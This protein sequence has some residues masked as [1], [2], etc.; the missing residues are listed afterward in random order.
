MRI[1][2]ITSFNARLF[3]EYAHR[4]LA[5]FEQFWDARVD[6]HV[7]SEDLLSC[8]APSSRARM[9]SLPLLAPWQTAFVE[10]HRQNPKAHGVRG[11]TK[12]MRWDAVRFSYKSAAVI[13]GYLASDHDLV[14]WVD[15][16]VITHAPVTLDYLES[17]LP[18]EYGLAWLERMSMYPECGFYVMRGQHDALLE[19]MRFW[20][21]MF[22]TDSIFRLKEWHDSFVLQQLVQF[23]QQ[24]DALNVLSLSGASG[25]RTSHPLING[26]LGERF[27]HLKG[28]RKAAGRSHKRELAVPRREAYWA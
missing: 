19:I 23:A 14:L 10:R 18:R 3:N 22:Y 21:S 9:R 27:D 6:L 1:L 4:F 16:D 7:Y 5:S 28:P 12:D 15:A 2:V 26:P 25:S 8:P 17:I 11:S 24:R 20:R 13:E